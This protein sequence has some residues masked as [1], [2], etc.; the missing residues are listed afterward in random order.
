MGIDAGI[1]RSASERLVLPVR[2]VL[3]STCI[4][5]LLSQPKVNDVDQV[6]LLPQPHQEVVWLHVSMD[7]VLGVD[8]LQSTD[9]CGVGGVGWGECM[10]GGMYMGIHVHS[11]LH[12]AKRAYIVRSKKGDSYPDN[13][14]NRDKQRYTRTVY[15]R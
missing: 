8:V 12:V 14:L 10:S 9:L 4:S 3:M 7:E 15:T 6:P 2:Y 11:T 5:V 13:H 1:S